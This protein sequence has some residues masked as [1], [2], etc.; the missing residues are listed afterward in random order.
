MQELI[1][2]ANS[3]RGWAA[4]RAQMALQIAAALEQRAID[5]GEA[6]ELLEDLVRTDRLDSE[7]DD[8]A[9]KTMLVT[10]IYAIIQ[11]I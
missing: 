1:T 3:G 8:I 4:E 9:L 10:G 2:C 11:V 5:P 6:R 7:A